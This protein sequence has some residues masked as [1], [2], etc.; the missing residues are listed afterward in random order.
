MYRRKLYLVLFVLTLCITP[1]AVADN[2]GSPAGWIQGLW[3][4]VLEAVGLDSTAPDASGEPSKTSVLSEPQIESDTGV[5]VPFGG[6]AQN[7]G[8]SPIEDP[9]FN[10]YPDPSG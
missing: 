5:A 8:E 10:G 2:G 1:A 6:P 3:E 4:T 9:D 7:D